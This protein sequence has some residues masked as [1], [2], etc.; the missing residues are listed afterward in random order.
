MSR[1]TPEDGSGVRLLKGLVVSRRQLVVGV[2]LL[3]LLFAVPD[4]AS[5]HPLLQLS[6][7]QEALLWGLTAVGLNLLLR[8][9]RLYSFGHGVFFGGGAYA[10]A[11][12]ASKFDVTAF[13]VLLLGSILV[14][15]VFAVLFVQ[16]VADG[17]PDRLA[18]VRELSRI[19]HSLDFLDLLLRNS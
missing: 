11:V 2:L 16:H 13:T 4:L 3:A 17:R 6:V 10:A 12:L 5:L 18:P 15:L 7:M 8:H 1:F 19:D 9:L 14:A